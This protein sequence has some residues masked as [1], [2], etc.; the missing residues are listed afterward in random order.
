MG[1]S[2]PLLT[3]AGPYPLRATRRKRKEHAR[4]ADAFPE[5]A[6]PRDF[7]ILLNSVVRERIRT[8]QFEPGR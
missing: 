6:H 7:A 3:V 8:K 4:R 2:K 5:A 1:E